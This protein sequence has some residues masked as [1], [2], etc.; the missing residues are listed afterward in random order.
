MKKNLHPD[1]QECTVT[2]ACGN[3]F[4][5]RGTTPTLQVDICSACHPF[6][7]GE[8]RF[9]DKQGR[10]D[11]FKQK[12]ATSAKLREAAKEK[13]LAKKAKKTADSQ[14]AATKSFKQILTAAKE[15]TKKAP[16]EK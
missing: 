6:F 16:V 2:C 3:T 5:T 14:P 12:M 7:T 8:E 9:V 15:E 11:K 10:I 4:V 13:Q 1:W